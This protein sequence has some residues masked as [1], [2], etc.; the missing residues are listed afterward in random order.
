MPCKDDSCPRHWRS[1]SRVARHGPA[2]I[3]LRHILTRSANKKPR[4][5]EGGNSS[6]VQSGGDCSTMENLIFAY[7]LDQA[8]DDGVLYPLG[9]WNGKPLIGTA[10]TVEDIPNEERQQLFADFL[11]WQKETEPTLAEED[12]MFV[13][14][15]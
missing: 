9:W 4:R 13:A 10:G 5:T 8:M 2:I 11:E 14:T 1:P 12:R 3:I 6:G 7:M 15:A